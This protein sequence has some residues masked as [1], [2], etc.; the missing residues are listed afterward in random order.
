MSKIWMCSECDALYDSQVDAIYCCDKDWKRIAQDRHALILKLNKRI[1]ELESQLDHI[2]DEW[3]QRFREQA[4][5]WEERTRM[6]R[7]QLDT[8]TSMVAQNELLKP[9]VIVINREKGDE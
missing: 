8:L 4:D 3:H 1:Q 5:H 7:K 2:D 9:P 6:I